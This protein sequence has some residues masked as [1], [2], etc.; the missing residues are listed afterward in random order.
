MKTLAQGLRKTL[1][2]YLAARGVQSLESRE[3]DRTR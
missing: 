1:D 3:G 2:W